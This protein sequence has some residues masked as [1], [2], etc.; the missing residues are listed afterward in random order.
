[1]KKCGEYD[2]LVDEHKKLKKCV[3][4]IQ[5]TLFFNFLS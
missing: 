3:E 5:I 1:M 2:K 4:L